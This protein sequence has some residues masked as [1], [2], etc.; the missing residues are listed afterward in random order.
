MVSQTSVHTERGES[1]GLGEPAD[2]GM[3]ALAGGNQPRESGD[4]LPESE[5]QETPED[6]RALVLVVEDNQ[7]DVFL[8]EQAVRL[9]KLPVRLLMLDNGED[10][11]RYFAH[12]DTDPAAPCP[13]AVLLDLNLP[14]RS[15]REVLEQVKSTVRCRHVP[16]IILTS[17]NSPEDRRET[18]ALGAIRYFRKPTSYQ[19]FLKIGEVLEEVLAEHRT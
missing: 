18:A 12:A 3:D 11:L 9:R 8:V 6:R 16:V 19:E 7:A 5:L 14:R 10:A 1:V 13:D 17:S 15:G 4:P 2:S